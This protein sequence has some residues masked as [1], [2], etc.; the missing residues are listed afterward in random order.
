MVK[1]LRVVIYSCVLM[2]AA[3]IGFVIAGF[4]LGGNKALIFDYKNFKFLSSEG[5]YE[6]AAVQLDSFDEI[7]IDISDASVVIE[8]GDKAAL[9]Y[10]VNTEK[11]PE[12]KNENG[13]LVISYKEKSS[14][15]V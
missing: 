1:S 2:L 11:K 12:V 15:V 9:E 8:E 14:S 5:K 4:I 3:G 10:S 13:K 6:K 7:S